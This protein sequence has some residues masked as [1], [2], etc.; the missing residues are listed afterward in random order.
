MKRKGWKEYA[1]HD[2]LMYHLGIQQIPGMQEEL[3]CLFVINGPCLH[4]GFLHTLT[5]RRRSNEYDDEFNWHTDLG[6]VTR[7]MVTIKWYNFLQYIPFY[8]S[9]FY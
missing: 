6:F 2:I 9:V 8:G 7:A 5:L 3:H 4:L 1:L